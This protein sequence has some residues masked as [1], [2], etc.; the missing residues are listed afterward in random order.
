MK[1]RSF[2]FAALVILIS[3]VFANEITGYKM[4]NQEK[5]AVATVAA[6]DSPQD[7]VDCTVRIKGTFDGVKVD[8]EITVYDVTWLE[9]QALKIGIK[10]AME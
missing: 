8:V 10:K 5:A 4:E 9:C 2:F 6:P 1:K 3:P 7:L